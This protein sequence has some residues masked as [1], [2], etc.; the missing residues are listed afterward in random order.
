M[1]FYCH[2]GRRK[3]DAWAQAIAEIKGYVGDARL[4]VLT[5]R[6]GTQRSYIFVVHPEHAARYE[7][8][9]AE[10]ISSTLWGECGKFTREYSI[11]SMVNAALDGDA[12]GRCPQVI[13]SGFAAPTI[14]FLH[15][16]G[17]T[18]LRNEDGTVTVLSPNTE[19]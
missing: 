1:V 3:D 5:Y 8:M 13:P 11:E 14:G 12:K 9:L 17:S 16:K 2:K 6:R 7:A 18:L 19:E 10:F 15:P 4:F